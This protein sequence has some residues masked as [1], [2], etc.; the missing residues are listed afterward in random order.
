MAAVDK[1]TFNVIKVRDLKEKINLRL[2]ALININHH[3]FKTTMCR[4]A[5]EDVYFILICKSYILLR[6]DS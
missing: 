2:R 5:I 3:F 1:S 4:G 6:K